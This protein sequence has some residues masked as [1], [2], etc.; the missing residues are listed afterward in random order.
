MAPSA[1]HGRDPLASLARMAPIT[2]AELEAGAALQV[3]RE[4]KYVITT[5][6]AAAL[7]ERL[8]GSHRALEIDGLRSFRYR[9]TYY[10]TPELLSYREHLQQRRRRFKCRRR[11]YVDA[12]TANLEVKLKGAGGTTVKHALASAPDRT[13]GPEELH[14][15]RERIAAECRRDIDPGAF[16]PTLVVVA[17]RI[18]LAAPELGERVTLDIAVDVP[19]W[20]L[21]PGLV[22]AEAKSRL[23]RGEADRALRDLGVFPQRA[24]KYCAGISLDGRDRRANRFLPFARHF[25]PVEARCA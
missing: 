3:R 4:H 19:G 15:L 21:A 22:I 9:T 7:L 5:A 24:S 10:D 25:E 18:T 12:G 1:S 6:E 20:R 2:L 23:G 16:A 14:F 17:R 13:L 8:A 11:H